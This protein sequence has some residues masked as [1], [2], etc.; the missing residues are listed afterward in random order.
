MTRAHALSLLVS[1]STDSTAVVTDEDLQ[2]MLKDRDEGSMV[3]FVVSDLLPQRLCA[4]LLHP[5]LRN[6]LR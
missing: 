1:V 4:G 5:S 3:W 6:N 2:S